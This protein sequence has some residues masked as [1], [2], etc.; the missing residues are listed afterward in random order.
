MSKPKRAVE[1]WQLERFTKF[2]P[3]EIDLAPSFATS[4]GKTFRELGLER[5]E[6][7]Y[8]RVA[9]FQ[10]YGPETALDKKSSLWRICIWGAD[11]LG[12]EC[13]VPSMDEALAVYGS[14]DWIYGVPAGFHYA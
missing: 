6:G 7:G 14:I 11:D 10:L 13:D 3:C 5:A 8:A 1:C 2:V 4:D 9:V 12:Y